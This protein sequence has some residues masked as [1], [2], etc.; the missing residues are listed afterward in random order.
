[1]IFKNYP[2]AVNRDKVGSYEAITNSGAGYF[3][4]EVL[5]YRVWYKQAGKQRCYFS[6][7][8]ADAKKF[9]KRTPESEKPVVLVRQF[10]HINE[11]SPGNYQLI[12]TARITEWQTSWLKRSNKRTPKNIERFNRIH[13]TNFSY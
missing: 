4:D 13:G 3:Y 11:P 10:K 9:H 5:E 2:S 8:Y 12:T 1:M 6:A 7:T